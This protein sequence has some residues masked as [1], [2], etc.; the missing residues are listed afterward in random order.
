MVMQQHADKPRQTL[1]TRRGTPGLPT[2]ARNRDQKY[3]TLVLRVTEHLCDRKWQIYLFEY[4]LYAGKKDGENEANIRGFQ[5][6]IGDLTH[7]YVIPHNPGS[8][9]TVETFLNPTTPENFAQISGSSLA[10]VLQA[11]AFYPGNRLTLV[12]YRPQWQGGEPIEFLM[13]NLDGILHQFTCKNILVVGDMNQHLVAR[14]FEDLLTIHGLNNDVDF[15]T[16]ISASS[17]GPVNS[18]RPQGAVS[19]Y[20]TGA[21][22]SSDH[23]AIFS[24]INLKATRE[25]ALTRTFWSWQGFRSVLENIAWDSIFT[26]VNTQAIKFTETPQNLQ[27]QNK[28]NHKA[29]FK[30]MEHV[31]KWAIEQWRQSL[32]TKLTNHSIGSKDWWSLVKQQQGLTSQDCIPPLYKPDGNLPSLTNQRLN[33]KVICVDEAKHHLLKT[34]VNKAFGPDNLSPYIPKSVLTSLQLHLPPYYKTVSNSKS[35]QLSGNR[36]EL[37]QC[38]KTTGA[39]DRVWHEGIISKLKSFGIDGDLLQ[40]IEDYR[41]GRTLQVV[42]NGCTSGEYPISASV[43]QGSVF[44]PLL[45]NVYFNNILHL[46][47]E[48]HAYADD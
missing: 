8:N 46:I 22:G 45:W 2:G 9:A 28:L 38:I 1:N 11:L 6:N 3:Q 26:D 18:D 30:R 37:W 40:M 32:S 25:E 47:P 43:P 14:S 10:Y 31:K 7:S 20:S 36:L 19:C 24:R 42:A 17:L 23:Y 41:R 16:H 27:K 39:F 29:A 48:T 12:C 33:S 15:P 4:L 44:G 13:N 21:V 5:A 34:D 35:G